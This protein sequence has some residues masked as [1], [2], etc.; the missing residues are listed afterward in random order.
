MNTFTETA[1]AERYKEAQA[2]DTRVKTIEAMIEAVR[3][4]NSYMCDDSAELSGTTILLAHI[5]TW[6]MGDFTDANLTGIIAISLD[7]TGDAIAQ[8]KEAAP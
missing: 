8:W 6:L 7:N 5:R 4:R 2:D 1:M 3:I